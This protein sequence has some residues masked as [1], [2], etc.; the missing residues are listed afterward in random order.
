MQARFEE[1]VAG[2]EGRSCSSRRR[3]QRRQKLGPRCLPAVPSNVEC[4]QT[5]FRILAEGKY[6]K[7]VRSN[8]SSLLLRIEWQNTQTLQ[9]KLNGNYLQKYLRC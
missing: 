7:Q 1:R 2:L 8:K 3:P 5:C 9:L 6:N 4:L